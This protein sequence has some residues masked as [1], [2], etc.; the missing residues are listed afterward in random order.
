MLKSALGAGALFGFGLARPMQHHTDAAETG[1][2][3][4]SQEW[5]ALLSAGY[6]TAEQKDLLAHAFS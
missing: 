6:T 1:R 3:P 5:E 2:M 4:A